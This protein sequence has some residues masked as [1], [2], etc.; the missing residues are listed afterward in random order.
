MPA[1]L[2]P[3]YKEAEAAYRRARE[4][5]ERLDCLREMLRTI[6]KHKGTEHLQADLKTRIKQL[7]EEVAGAKKSGARGV[8]VAIKPEGA[9]QIALLGPPNAG[10]SSLHARLTAS[11]AEASVHPFTTKIPLPG[12]MPF[13]DI[14]LQLVDL[15]P[16][17]ADF[18]ESFLPNALS[19]ADGALLVVDIGDPAAIEDVPAIRER[20][21]SKHIRLLGEDRAPAEDDEEAPR[22][23]E[24]RLPTLLV[25]NKCDRMEDPAAEL[26]VFRELSGAPYPAIAV[27]VESGEGLSMLG[28]RLF[29]M[30]GIVRVYTKVP[31]HAPDR[32][33]PFALRRG[34][35]VREVARLVRPGFQGEV[36]SARI[37]GAHCFPGQQVGRDHALADGDVVELSW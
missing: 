30:L 33:R 12:M 6:P 5:K 9:A 35:T 8:S 22:A 16:I 28:Q 18:M 19:G 37:W 32:T 13:E 7:T 29:E 20:L 24:A 25:A 1:N 17:S 4:P 31:G 2:S 14:Q 23:L 34:D 11:R 3:D 15:P 10:K 27:S 26:S 36:R 21:L